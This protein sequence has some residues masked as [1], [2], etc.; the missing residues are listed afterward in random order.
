MNLYLIDGTYELFRAHFGAP[1][2]SAPDGRPIGAVTGLVQ[3]LL[4]L[5]REERPDFIAC[6]FD[7]VVESFRNDLFDGYKTGDGVPEDLFA[8]FSLAETATRSLGITVWPMVEFEADDAIA[9]ATAKWRDDPNL[10]K[11][12]ICSV[13]KDLMNLVDSSRVVLWDRRRNLTY[14]EAQVV[15]RFGVSPHSIP[16]YLALVG[17]SADGIPGVP[18]WGAKSTAT[19]LS[20]YG[21]MENIPESYDDWTTTV[22]GG[23]ALAQNLSANREN[24]LLYKTLATLRVDAPVSESLQAVRWEGVPQREYLDFCDDLGLERLKDLPHRWQ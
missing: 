15:E 6:A 21:L 13:D 16:D 3:S 7:H 11:I 8:Q 5:L 20:E 17:D 12:V 14:T 2:R 24:A 19:V 22:R 10:E 4:L 23:K 1:P 9:S 18:R